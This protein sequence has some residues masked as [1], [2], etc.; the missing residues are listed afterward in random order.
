MELDQPQYAHIS[1]TME[2]NSGPTRRTPQLKVEASDLPR[3]ITTAEI[4]GGCIAG[5]Q[6]SKRLIIVSLRAWQ[7]PPT[8][9]DQ[10]RKIAVGPASRE[11]MRLAANKAHR[12]THS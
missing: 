2:E 9:P 4:V 1:L 3:T 8:A 7:S 10:L 5:V 6:L 12:V 11:I